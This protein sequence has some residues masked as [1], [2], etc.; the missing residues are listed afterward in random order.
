[1]KVMVKAYVNIKLPEELAKEVDKLVKER[2]LGYRSRGEFVIEA[3]RT[4]LIKVKALKKM[5]EF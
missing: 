1:V 2:M 5:E 4:L 3:T